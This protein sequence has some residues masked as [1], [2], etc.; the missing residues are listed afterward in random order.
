[1]LTNTTQFQDDIGPDFLRRGP[2]LDLPVVSVD[3]KTLESYVGTYEVEPGRNFAVRLENDGTLTFQ[4]PNN[5]R[6]R[7]YAHSESGF[8]IK[9]APWR[10]TFTK[11]DAGKVIG[12]VGDLEGT[13]RRATKV[14][15]DTPSSRTIAGNAPAD[16]PKQKQ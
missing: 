6:F 16:P 4:V 11:D 2:P 14:S 13:E 5:V 10:V 8:F 3:R 1:M 12:L 7:M 15:S 9:R